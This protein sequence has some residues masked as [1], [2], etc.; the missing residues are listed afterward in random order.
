MLHHEYIYIYICVYD[1]IND[2]YSFNYI[3]SE[4]YQHTHT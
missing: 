4:R 3:D 2:V 1:F